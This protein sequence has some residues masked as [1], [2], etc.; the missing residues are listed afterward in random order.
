LRRFDP[1]RRKRRSFGRF[2][3]PVHLSRGCQ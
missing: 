1:Q 2:S 3:V